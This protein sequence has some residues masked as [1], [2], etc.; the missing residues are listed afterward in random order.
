MA[1]LRAGGNASSVHAEGRA[2]RAL[3]EQARREVAALVGA[4]PER[5]TFTSGGSEGAAMLLA[6]GFRGAGRPPAE[7]AIVSA[8]EHSCVLS[9]G[10]F[11]A[12][13]VSVCPVTPQGV[14]DLAAL[15]R[16]LAADGRP[17]LVAI[18]AANNE[19]GVVQPVERASDIA[20]RFGASV[21]CDAVQAL[22]KR[23]I[24]VEAQSA[25][26]LV[27]SGHKIGAPAG[28][29]AIVLAAGAEPPPAL[30]RGGGQERKRRAGTENLA[31]IAGFGAAA[32]EVRTEMGA[33]ISR[34]GS[35]RDWIER[36]LRTM[37]PDAVILGGGADRLPNTSCFAVRGLSGETAVIA[38]DLAGVSVATGSAC[39]SGKVTP[40]H[41]LTAMG[42]AP[43]LARAAL[44]VSLGWSSQAADAERFVAVLAKHRD[45]VRARRDRAA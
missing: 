45:T 18:M 9:G 5:V 39:A 23:E 24:D 8:V 19:T 41:V 11:P 43:E 21:L 35:L 2:A 12:D 42:L 37:S 25:D 3:I 26:A 7:R 4:A 40:S 15:E 34:I 28:V 22:G 38:C 14:V 30:V 31:G 33:E 6:P 16:L 1:A 44:R 20:R 36:A 17:A 29:G 32:A 27:L 10:R 13:L